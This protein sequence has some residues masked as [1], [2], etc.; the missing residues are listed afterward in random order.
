MWSTDGEKQR[1]RD[2]APEE[3]YDLSRRAIQPG[4]VVKVEEGDTN[5]VPHSKFT[6]ATPIL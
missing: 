3:Y 4:E 1:P 6:R 2:R 5:W